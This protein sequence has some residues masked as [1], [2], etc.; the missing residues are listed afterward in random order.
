MKNFIRKFFRKTRKEKLIY[1]SFS[2]L[3]D[4]Y[5]LEKQEKLLIEIAQEA[6]KEQRELINRYDRTIEPLR[7]D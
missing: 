3:F 1:T 5:P 6:N 4:N 2:N 7:K